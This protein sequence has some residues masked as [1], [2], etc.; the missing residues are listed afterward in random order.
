MVDGHQVVLR[1]D[2]AGAADRYRV[3]IA[4]DADFHDVVFEQDVPGG[5]KALVV[6]LHFP[7]DDRLFYWRVL[8]GNAEGWSAGEHIEAFTSGTAEQAGRFVVP[9]MAEPFGPV[10]AL[11]SAATLESVA[12]VLPGYRRRAEAALGGERP[13]GGEVLGVE[14]GLLVA[15]ALVLGA[16]I[17]ILLSSC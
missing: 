13:D 16:L 9:D 8:A 3:Q 2:P 6:S 17:F 10:A 12:E 4:P 15:A 11:F 7:D 5:T 14:V 1:W